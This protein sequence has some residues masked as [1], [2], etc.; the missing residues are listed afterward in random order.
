MVC[1]GGAACDGVPRHSQ[2]VGIRGGQPR[3]VG[4]RWLGVE[5][6]RRRWPAA[7][8]IPWSRCVGNS[9]RRGRHGWWCARARATGP[10]LLVADYGVYATMWA[11]GMWA[12]AMA[13]PPPPPPPGPWPSMHTTV[14][15]PRTLWTPPKQRPNHKRH[16]PTPSRR[17][18][19]DDLLPSSPSAP[20]HVHG[21]RQTTCVSVARRQK[22]RLFKV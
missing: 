1:G 18:S 3:L 16:A 2:P 21:L 4:P 13:T 11:I 17:T 15:D 22:N 10:L 14:T 7:D 9:S 20:M 5:R 8:D 12:M 19:S 6:Q